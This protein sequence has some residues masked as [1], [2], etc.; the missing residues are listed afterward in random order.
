M[1]KPLSI[2]RTQPVRA[3]FPEGTCPRSTLLAQLSELVGKDDV[4]SLRVPP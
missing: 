2:K 1:E 4:P 3:V